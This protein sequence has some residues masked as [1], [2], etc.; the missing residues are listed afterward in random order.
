MLQIIQDLRSGETSLFEVPIPSIRPGCVLI[1]TTKS[2]VSIGTERSLV[3]FGKANLINKARQQPEKVAMV[4]DK[5]Q[6][7]GLVPTLEAVFKKLDQPLPLGYCNVG[8]IIEVGEGVTD[9][10]I[11]DR[12]VSNGPHAEFVC[13]PQNLIAPIPESVSDDQAAFTVIGS[14]GLQGIRL[15]DPTLGETIVVIGLGLIGL[16]TAQLLQMN[17]CKVI[18]VDIDE[19]KTKLAEDLGINCCPPGKYQDPVSFIRQATDNLGADGVIITASTKSNQV[20]AQAARMSRKRGRIVL[21][22][23]IGLNLSRSDFYQKELT[24]Q[25]SCSYGPGRYDASYEDQGIDYPA[26][27][28]RWTENRNFRAILDALNRGALRVDPMISNQLEL[29]EF[30]RIYGEIKDDKS[31]ATILNY[32]EFPPGHDHPITIKNPT[33]KFDS[34]KPVIA[35]IGAGNFVRMTLL[36][37]L[38]KTDCNVKY[39]ASKDGLNS[40]VLSKKYDIE[41]SVTDH[42]KILEDPTVNLVIIATRHNLHA[43]QVLDCLKAGKHVF[44]E[45]PLCLNLEELE[46]IVNC[47]NDHEK[48]NRSLLTVGFNRRFSPHVVKAKELIGNGEQPISMVIT[49]NAGFIPSDSWV[50]DLKQGGGRI[51]GEACHFFDLA[52]FLCNSLITRVCMSGLGIDPKMDTDNA[53]ILLN[54][55]NGS[56]AVVNYFA[57]GSQKYPKERIEVHASG[58]SMVIDNFRTTR[59]YGFKE[60]KKLNTRLDKGHDKQ[61]DL[62]VSRMK[63]SGDALIPFDQI[64]NTSKASFSA[65]KSLSNSSWISVDI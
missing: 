58:K 20:I 13:V 31:I 52:V 50:Q 22:G 5:I 57:N 61:F 39:I 19:S 27:Y 38:S 47:Y 10:K 63:E 8:K 18:G 12:V 54:F 28:V 21:V 33:R 3:E 49:I 30:N 14:I 62:L 34:K 23:V 6:A 42:Q 44:V 4:L 24:F 43:G 37:S 25:V 48:G 11:G 45:K 53:S 35:V 29:H 51:I 15:C 9:Y 17:G 2:L 26:S 1:K 56:T 7:E 32:P 46:Q 59:G 16:L 55:A 65:L 41:Y 40:T 60:F 64:V 36:P